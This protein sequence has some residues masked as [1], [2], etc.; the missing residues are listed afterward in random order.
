MSGVY[1]SSGYYY[2]TN[3]ITGA[4]EHHGGLDLTA[5]GCYGH[6]VL[7]CASGT[8]VT[9]TYHY[10]WGN[11]ILIDHGNGLATLY[12]HLSGFAVSAGQS[13]SQGQTIGY[14]GSTGYSTGPH[15]HVEVWVNG[16]R[17]NP[18][19]YIPV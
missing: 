9:A 19:G 12:A 18:A 5:G 2:R 8:V 14:V 4:S 3:P 13:V 15:L 11:Y 10:S 6:S 17:V 1:V 7:A 16:S